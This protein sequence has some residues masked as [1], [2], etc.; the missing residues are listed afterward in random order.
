MNK[1]LLEYC[2]KNEKKIR[3]AIE[4]AKE[5]A[6]K[7]GSGRKSGISRP[8]EAQ[9]IFN[10]CFQP[11]SVLIDDYILIRKPTTVLLLVSTIKGHFNQRPE[12]MVYRS[13]YIKKEKWT[14]YCGDNKERK[15][16]YYKSVHTILKYGIQL[17]GDLGLNEKR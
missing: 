5:D 17:A 8:T 15:Y 13:R 12:G 16:H 7:K 9:A 11:A 4:W 1:K 14:A 6:K 3:M 10:I 2:L